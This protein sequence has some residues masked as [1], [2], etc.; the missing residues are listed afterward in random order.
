MSV[1]VR[2]PRGEDEL[3]SLAELEGWAFG[4]GADDAAQWLASAGHENARVL[5]HD[6][7]V[8]GGL[9]Q[10]PMGQFFGGRSV[11]MVGIA[12]VAVAPEE[13]GRGVALALMEHTVRELAARGVAVSTLYPATLTLYR[14]AGWELA[15]NHFEL[16]VKLREIGVREKAGE[17][18]A[19]T[20]ADDR[21]IEELYSAVARSS[22]GYADRGAYLWRRVRVPRNGAARGTLV[23][24][25]GQVEGYLYSV[26]RRVGAFGYDL[27][28]TDLVATTPRAA[29]RLL[30]F[31]G[32][33]RSVGEHAIWYGGAHGPLIAAMPERT[34][35][36]RLVEHWMLRVCN[37]EAALTARGYPIG[38]ELELELDLHDPVVAENSGKFVLQ[39][40]NGTGRVRRGGRGH[41]S[42]GTR[43]LSALYTGFATPEDLRRQDLLHCDDANAAMAAT[44]FAGPT[45]DLIDFF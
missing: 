24:F 23:S 10:I 14:K 8:P 7:K 2:P 36:I 4:Y 39:I 13:R 5:V 6:G 1:V 40:A 43:G 29:R 19:I 26:P 28:L 44:V 42:L 45:P 33:H 21:T 37:V 20:E 18:R 41:L 17:L 32:E 12:G 9:L 22:C 34:Y 11:P 15:G 38:V 16:T 30:A 25:D 31:L 3:R 35:S 27:K